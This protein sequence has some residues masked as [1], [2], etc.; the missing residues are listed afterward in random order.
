MKEPAV[1]ILQDSLYYS[2]TKGLYNLKSEKLANIKEKHPKKA[3][4][5]DRLLADYYHSTIES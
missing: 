5:M 3:A 4:E 2:K 1:C